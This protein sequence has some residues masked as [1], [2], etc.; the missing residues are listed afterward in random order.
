[1]D[2]K[3]KSYIFSI[4]ITFVLTSALTLVGS[5][6]Y[7]ANAD[8]QSQNDANNNEGNNNGEHDHQTLAE[9]NALQLIADGRQTFRFDTLGDEAFWGDA[10]HLHQ[11]IEGAQ[12]GGVGPGVSPKKALAVGLKVDVDALPGALI[13]RIKKGDLNLDDPANTLAL[14]K[15]NAVVGVDRFFRGQR[16]PTL[17]RDSVRSVP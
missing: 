10:L 2:L 11:A 4:L 15:L 5:S 13:E 12:F 17:H 6:V 16:S 7:T 3:T 9:A 1:M 14:L 8:N